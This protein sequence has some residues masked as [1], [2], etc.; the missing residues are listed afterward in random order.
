MINLN[1]Y[2]NEKLQL[3]KNIKVNQDYELDIPKVPDG[4]TSEISDDT[5]KIVNIPK[6]KYIIYID[7]YRGRNYHFASLGDFISQ[8]IYF[9]DDYED[10]NPNKDIV[11]YGDDL[12]DVFNWYVNKLKI[13]KYLDNNLEW[14]EIA[15]EINDNVKTTQDSGEFFARVFLGEWDEEDLNSYA[16]IT[17]DDELNNTEKFRDWVYKNFSS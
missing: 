14:E 13:N 1:Q 12:Q 2:I 8:L 4:D 6:A 16:P 10:F 3:N 11:Y 17:N 9:Q 5:W 15:K 7:K